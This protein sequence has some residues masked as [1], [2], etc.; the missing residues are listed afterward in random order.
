LKPTIL[1]DDDFAD[2]RALSD[3]KLR[4]AGLAGNEPWDGPELILD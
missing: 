3:P 4:E 2:L 1:R